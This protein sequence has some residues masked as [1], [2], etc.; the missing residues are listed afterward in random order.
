MY[1]RISP[2]LYT[3]DH[4]R[5]KQLIVIVNK[6]VSI[7]IIKLINSRRIIVNVQGVHDLQIKT[8]DSTKGNN[9]NTIVLFNKRLYN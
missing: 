9:T 8:I 1:P 7:A 3:A 6:I 5:P 4:L 2:N